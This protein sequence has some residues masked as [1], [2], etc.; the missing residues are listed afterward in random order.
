MKS[1]DWH[2]LHELG[3]LNQGLIHINVID[4]SIGG[5]TRMAET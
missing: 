1:E 3:F 2:A 5:L 4:D